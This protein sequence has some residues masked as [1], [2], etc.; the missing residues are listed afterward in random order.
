VGREC[1]DEDRR[2][3]AMRISRMIETMPVFTTP[4]STEKTPCTVSGLDFSGGK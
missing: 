1:N 2:R 4:V 3:F